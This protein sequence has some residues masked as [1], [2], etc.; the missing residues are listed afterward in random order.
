MKD[1]A[2]VMFTSD[3][4]KAVT[5]VKEAHIFEPNCVKTVTDLPNE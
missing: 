4:D 5:H 3:P 2:V 1:L